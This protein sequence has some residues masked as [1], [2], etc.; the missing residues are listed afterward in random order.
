MFKSISGNDQFLRGLLA[1][2]LLSAITGAWWFF[3]YWLPVHIK[4]EEVRPKPEPNPED[5]GELPDYPDSSP[6]NS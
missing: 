6:W 4:R 2:V 5:L 3:V 1:L